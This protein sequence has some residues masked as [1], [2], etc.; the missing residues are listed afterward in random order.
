MSRAGIQEQ[1]APGEAEMQPASSGPWK[2]TDGTF[3][4]N[5]SGELKE[6]LFGRR[7]H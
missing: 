7:D 4:G 1:A 3:K 5:N 6:G 2:E